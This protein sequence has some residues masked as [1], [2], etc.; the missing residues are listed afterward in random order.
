MQ[1]R[2]CSILL[3]IA[4]SLRCEVIFAANGFTR[5]ASVYA[6]HSALEAVQPTLAARK[7]IIP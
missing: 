6:V 1:G 5:V 7:S 3:H 2:L 4:L